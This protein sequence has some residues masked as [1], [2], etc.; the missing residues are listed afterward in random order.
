[1]KLKLGKVGKIM[2][3]SRGSRGPFRKALVVAGL[4][5]ADSTVR[6][7]LTTVVFLCYDRP[8]LILVTT[9]AVATYCKCIH[10]FV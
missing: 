10:P 7:G 4:E 2:E 9:D 8:F 1:M 5:A 3:L 6:N